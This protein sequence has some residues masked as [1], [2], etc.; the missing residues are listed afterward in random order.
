[1]DGLV[2]CIGVNENINAILIRFALNADVL[3]IMPVCFLP[4]A[5]DIDRTG[6]DGC[7]ICNGLQNF[8]L[9]EITDDCSAVERLGKEVYLATGSRENIKITTPL[10]LLIAEAILRGRDR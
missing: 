8:L 2:L 6:G 7:H 4:I 5:A 3:G 9:T 1:M 10:D